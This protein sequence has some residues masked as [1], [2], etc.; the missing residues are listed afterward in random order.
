MHEQRGTVTRRSGDRVW[1]RTDDPAGSCDACAA[2]GGCGVLRWP[3]HRRLEFSLPVDDDSP[4]AAGDAVTVSVPDGAVVVGALAQYLVPLLGLVGG[5]V[6]AATALGAQS[7][8]ATGAGAMGGL[9]AGLF[10]AR[11][12]AGTFMRRGLLV[13]RVRRGIGNSGSINV[14][15]A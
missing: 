11:L 2:G 6:I 8:V 10:A 15:V 5:A 1:V 14:E 12:L 4:L 7:D 13:A 3:S 9:L